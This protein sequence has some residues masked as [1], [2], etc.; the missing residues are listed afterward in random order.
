MQKEIK[1]MRKQK[2]ELMVEINQLENHSRK[3]AECLL[4]YSKSDKINIMMPMTDTFQNKNIM[5]GPN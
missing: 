3:Y 5:K 1:R 4:K 2:D